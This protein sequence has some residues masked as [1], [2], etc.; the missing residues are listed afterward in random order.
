MAT[1]GLKP[2]LTFVLDVP[3]KIA[4]QR[5]KKNSKY[6]DG[7]RMEKAGERFHDDV[8]HGFLKLAE[9]LMEQ[10]RIK[11]INAAPPKTIKEIHLEIVN[12]VSKALWI[13]KAGE[14]ND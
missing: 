7:D 10:D 5:A 11:V 14:I 6:E 4:L 1:N 9:S 2:D 13:P 12:Y 3:T 8:R